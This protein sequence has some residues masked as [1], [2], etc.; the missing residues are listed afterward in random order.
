MFY[1]FLLGVAIYN[2]LHM[3]GLG[4]LLPMGGEQLP[5]MMYKYISIMTEWKTTH[6]QILIICYRDAFLNFSMYIISN[7]ILHGA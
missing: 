3:K 5:C 2:A 6:E 4:K 1:C 7:L